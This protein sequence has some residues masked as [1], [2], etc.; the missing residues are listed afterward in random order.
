MQRW[1]VG[2]PAAHVSDRQ[3]DGYWSTVSIVVRGV[4][5]IAVFVAVAVAPL[6]FAA[7][8]VAETDRGFATEFSARSGSS[9]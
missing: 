4:V 1:V 2:C 8:G 7:V 6:V 5:W 9:A 3:H